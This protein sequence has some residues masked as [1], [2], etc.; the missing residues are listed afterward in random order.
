M[1]F[2]E[3]FITVRDRSVTFIDAETGRTGSDPVDVL[4]GSFEDAVTRGIRSAISFKGA[5]DLIVHV[6]DDRSSS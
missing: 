1:A 2:T 6:S 3:I 5:T 4:A